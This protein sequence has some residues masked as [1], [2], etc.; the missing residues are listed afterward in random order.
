[1]LKKEMKRKKK[2][3]IKGFGTGFILGAFSCNI[4]WVYC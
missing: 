1:M 3:A 4:I 2:D